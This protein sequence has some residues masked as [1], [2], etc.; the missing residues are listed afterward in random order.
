M[1]GLVQAVVGA[2]VEPEQKLETAFT[3]E[4]TLFDKERGF[5]ESH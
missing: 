3:S 1:E 5:C 2:W 4:S